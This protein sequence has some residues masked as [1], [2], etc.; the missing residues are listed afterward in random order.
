RA[1]R[2]RAV[3]GEGGS[4]G[5]TKR[6]KVS[7]VSAEEEDSAVSAEEEDSTSNR[8][9]NPSFLLK[10]VDDAGTAE[11]QEDEHIMTRAS[12]SR[13]DTIK[14]HP[15]DETRLTETPIPALNPEKTVVQ[16]LVPVVR[17]NLA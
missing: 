8:G 2:K 12:P 15:A 14:T 3:D 5:K 1:E 11:S 10:D 4:K 17:S 13:E 7:T 6:R 16:N 9:A